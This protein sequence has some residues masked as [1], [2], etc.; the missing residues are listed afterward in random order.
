MDSES[1][2][3]QFQEA[4]EYLNLTEL[5][6]EITELISEIIVFKDIDEDLNSL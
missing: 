1:G 5:E 2:I 3:I 6:N 4:G